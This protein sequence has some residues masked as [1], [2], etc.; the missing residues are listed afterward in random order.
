MNKQLRNARTL[1]SVYAINPFTLESSGRLI[2]A[3]RQT[4]GLTTSDKERL[5]C[6]YNLTRSLQKHIMILQEGIILGAGQ[7]PSKIIS[8]EVAKRLTSLTASP[9]AYS[10]GKFSYVDVDTLR[11]LEVLNKSVVLT[12]NVVLPIKVKSGGY[13]LNAQIVLSQNNVLS[14]ASNGLGYEE[15]YAKLYRP[16]KIESLGNGIKKNEIIEKAN[17][18]SA[19][20]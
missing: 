6:E 1:E 5:Q 18:N 7:A 13:K 4:H 20:R 16:V 14:Y 9:I 3:Q 11:N 19:T 12:K 2:K 10:E 15:N 17:A 8:P